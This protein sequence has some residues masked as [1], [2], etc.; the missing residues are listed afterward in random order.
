MLKLGVNF[1][2]MAKRSFN[3]I[4]FG[5]SE[6]AQGQLDYLE[7][8][9]NILIFIPLGVYSAVLSKRWTFIKKLSVPFLIS[10]LF[11]ALQFILRIG[12][13]DITDIFT[14]TIG[15]LLGLFLPMV[16]QKIFKDQAR[17]QKLINLIGVIGT[18]I[19]ITLLLLLKL[20]L[21]PIRYQ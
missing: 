13:F 5:G 3:L 7:I 11:E 2:Y 19:I 16:L 12:A 20:N 10:F 8:V 17:T 1:S 4:P 14:N 9:L 21:L 6:N 18:L 15:G